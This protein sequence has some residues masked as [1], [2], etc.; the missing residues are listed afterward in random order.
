MLAVSS[1]ENRELAVVDFM[2]LADASLLRNAY[3][4]SGQRF[5]CEKPNA[6]SRA[7]RTQSETDSPL[8]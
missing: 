1:L 7:C 5:A 3:G 4:D 8:R 6:I 2:R